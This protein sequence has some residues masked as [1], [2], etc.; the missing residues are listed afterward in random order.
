MTVNLNALNLTVK[1]G[2]R[3][4]PP[5][6]DFPAWMALTKYLDA[7]LGPIESGN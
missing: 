4:L 3:R 1:L 5:L 6:S 7:V 2:D